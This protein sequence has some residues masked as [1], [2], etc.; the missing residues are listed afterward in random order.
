[1]LY[2]QEKQDAVLAT[3]I[4]TKVAKCISSWHQVSTQHTHFTVLA[5]KSRLSN[6]QTWTQDEVRTHIVK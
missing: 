4:S 6:L 5:T 1:M 2:D 3:E